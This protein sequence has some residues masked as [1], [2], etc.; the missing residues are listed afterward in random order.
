MTNNNDS[1][2]WYEYNHHVTF[3][4]TNMAGNV[5]FATYVMWMGKCRDLLMGEHYPQLK[6]H[7]NNGFGFST[8][9]VHVDYIHETF[10][11]DEVIVRLTISNLTRTRVEFL[12]EF[13]N[14]ANNTLLAKGSQAVVW[15]NP[16]RRPSFMPDDLYNKSCEYFS[17]Q[18]D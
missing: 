9:F 5:Y 3:A 14:A 17:I 15:V 6:N 11:F 10:L 18:P 12:C 8:E 2:K 7:I 16:Q 13:V 4:D 1:I